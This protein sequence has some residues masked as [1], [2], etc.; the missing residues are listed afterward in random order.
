MERLEEGLRSKMVKVIFICAIC[1]LVLDTAFMIG[2][3]FT[4]GLFY[5]VPVYIVRRLLYPFIVNILAYIFAKIT[6][7]SE[8]LCGASKNL[9]C[10]IAMCTVCGSMAIFHSS[11]TPLWVVPGMMLLVSSV[12]HDEKI[13]R[14]LLLYSSVLVVFAMLYVSSERPEQKNIYIEM[15]IAVEALNYLLYIVA[16]TVQRYQTKVQ[17]LIKEANRNETKYRMR[18]ERDTLTKVHSRVYI[19]EIVDKTFEI[20]DGKDEIGLAVLDLDN[21]KRINDT[22]GHDNGDVVL[23]RLGGLLNQYVSDDIIV[24]RFGG[25][26]FVIIFRGQAINYYDTIEEIRQRFSEFTFE[27]MKD[28]MTF[29]TGLV[30]CSSSVP[31]KTAFNTADEALYESKNNGKNRVTIRKI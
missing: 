15:C 16:K 6:N 18:L 1:C 13:Q 22:Y 24:G 3:Y 21:F 27:F 28:N 7:V 23:E 20:K 8:K 10:C 31:Y 2:L 29:S 5:S 30:C 19:Q 9:T 26:E 4:T 11:Y 25:E 14:I 12:F 17:D